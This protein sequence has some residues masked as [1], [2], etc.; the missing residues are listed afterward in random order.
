MI[1]FLIKPMVDCYEMAY[2][3]IMTVFVSR[4]GHRSAAAIV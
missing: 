3:K 1:D 2:Q 4:N